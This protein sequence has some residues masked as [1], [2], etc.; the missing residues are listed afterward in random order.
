MEHKR[1]MKTFSLIEA[2]DPKK[3]VTLRKTLRWSKTDLARE[4]GVSDLAVR[5][6]EHG[7]SSPKKYAWKIRRLLKVAECLDCVRKEI[8]DDSSLYRSVQNIR[9]H[10]KVRLKQLG[11]EDQH[12]AVEI[13]KKEM[14]AAELRF[15]EGF[16]AS[17]L[18]KELGVSKDSI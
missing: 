7:L 13:L 8:A 3:I 1:K 14:A 2:I 17:L 11:I 6:W 9:G 4:V 16:P 12:R 5:Y 15:E 10:K 18:S